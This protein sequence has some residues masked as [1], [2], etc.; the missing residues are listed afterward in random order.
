MIFLAFEGYNDLQFFRSFFTKIMKARNITREAPYLVEMFKKL[1][2][3]NPEVRVE[4][5]SLNNKKLLLLSVGGRENFEVIAKGLRPIINTIKKENKE[6]IRGIAFIADEDAKKQVNA[7]IEKLKN[8][9]LQVK[10][11]FYKTHLE[12][13]VLHITAFTTLEENSKKLLNTFFSSIEKTFGNDKHIK[14]RKLSML[15]AI[16]GPRC[17]GHLFDELFENTDSQKI[18]ENSDILRGLVDWLAEL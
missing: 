4:I 6:N 14:K 1:I 13:V 15:H 16:V 9:D 5:L 11:I 3:E 12:D 17:F 2:I 8:L 18:L 10:K 7:A